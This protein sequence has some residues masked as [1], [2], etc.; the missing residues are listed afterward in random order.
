MEGLTPAARGYIRVQKF[1]A[2]AP[3]APVAEAGRTVAAARVYSGTDIWSADQ[4]KNA[5]AYLLL[6]LKLDNT[7]FVFT[8]VP[9][10]DE[11]GHEDLPYLYA[12]VSGMTDPDLRAFA[13]D[14]A[15]CLLP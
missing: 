5:K 8:S 1:N 6:A 9:A 11:A 2:G 15:A 7:E 14:C 12:L 13:E 4:Q 3:F 10:P